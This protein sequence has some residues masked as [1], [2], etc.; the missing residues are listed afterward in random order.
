MA[1]TFDTIGKVKGIN[2]KCT[3]THQRESESQSQA[4]ECD[5]RWQC[6]YV[7]GGGKSWRKLSLK[8]EVD[9]GQTERQRDESLLDNYL[10]LTS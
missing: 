4:R 5:T 9:S 7:Q 8:V 10:S 1:K 2:G 3:G 6:R